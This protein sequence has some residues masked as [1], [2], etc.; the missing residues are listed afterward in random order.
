MPER[1]AVADPIVQV[2]LSVPVV[3]LHSRRDR[4][5]PFAQSRT[6]VAAAR[7]AGAEVELVEVRGGHLAHVD[8]NS[9]AWAA[10]LDVLPRLS[11]P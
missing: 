11:G 6:Y 10:V 3:C 5:V 9:K 2:P 4:S 7:S 1:Y 8:P